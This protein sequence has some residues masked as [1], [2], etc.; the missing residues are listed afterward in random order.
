M[1]KAKTLRE[2]RKERRLTVREV[3]EGSG[4]AFSTYTAYEYEYRSPSIEAAKKL[5][6]FYKVK[7]D[8]IKFKT[9][10]R[11]TNVD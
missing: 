5:A 7:V 11:T 3:S 8:D 6:A 4:I 9:K 1:A 10:E 2:L